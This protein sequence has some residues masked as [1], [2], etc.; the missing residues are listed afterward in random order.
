M[1]SANETVNNSRHVKIFDT[2]L[3]DGQ[4]C[5]GAGMSIEQNL[6]YARLACDLR[7]DVLEAGFPSASDLDFQIVRTICE[8]I[9]GYDYKPTVAGLCQLREEQIIRTVE[10]LQPLVQYKKARLHTYVP[11]DPELMHAS[12]GKLAD[13]KGRIVEDLYRLTKMAVDNGMEVQFSPEGYSR[14]GGN[15]DFVTELIRAAIEGGAVVIN[16]PDTIG[17]A[18]IWEGEEYFVRKMSKHAAIMKAEFPEREITWSV[19]CHNDF[20]LAVQNSINAVVDGPCT[21]IEGCINGIGERAGNA[22]LEQCIMILKH[23]SQSVDKDDPYFTTIVTDKLQ[24][25]SD[26]VGH[27]MLPRQPHWPVSGDNAAKHSSGGHT[28]AILK[29][30]MAYQPFD[31]S[32]I[33]KEIT[34]LFGPLSGGNHAKSIIEAAGYKCDDSEKAEIAQYIKNQYPQRR[35]G[36][37]DSELMDSYMIFRS[38]IAIDAVEYSKQS[39]KATVKLIGTI[40]GEAGTIE[41]E[42]AGKDSALAA[43]KS[44]LEK[45][46]GAI[47][48]LNHRSHSDSVG[49]D[50]R[51]ISEIMIADSENNQY[52]GKASDHDIE[53]SAIKAFIDAVNKA[54][55]CRTYATTQESREKAAKPRLSVA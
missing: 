36:I 5:P 51:S 3:R 45:R 10:S 15:F 24:E 19:H 7:V 50:A 4:Q 30:P 32:D 39:G 54:Y 48:I 42:S 40:F 20:G 55:V 46:F 37:T 18:A 27:N 22:A 12:L 31:P 34:F 26:F 23:F 29:N 52:M 49:I 44:A 6:Q 1:K 35:K 33:G 13:D 14:V 43:V 53:I 25:I 21:Q 38:P 28:N 2:T 8:D 41:E 9:A 17:G 11:V 16:C 47:Q